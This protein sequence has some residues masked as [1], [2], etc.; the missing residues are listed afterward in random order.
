M[1]YLFIQYDASLVQLGKSSLDNYNDTDDIIKAPKKDLSS[2]YDKI[3]H[4]M[5]ELGLVCAIEVS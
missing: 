1:P 2:Y 3:C 4:C 5:D